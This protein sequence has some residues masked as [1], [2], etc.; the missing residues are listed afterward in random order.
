M[1]LVEA[2]R[3]AEWAHGQAT[4]QNARK[5][6]VAAI[7]DE[8]SPVEWWAACR[9]VRQC[10]PAF[11]GMKRALREVVDGG[12]NS[13]FGMAVRVTAMRRLGEVR[14][15][16]RTEANI[17][18]AV[19]C[20]D[21]IIQ[22]QTLSE[23][24]AGLGRWRKMGAARPPIPDARAAAPLVRKVTLAVAKHYESETEGEQVNEFNIGVSEGWVRMDDQP[25]FQRSDIPGLERS[26]F[27]VTIT[28]Y[29]GVFVRDP[30][31]PSYFQPSPVDVLAQISKG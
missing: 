23:V 10:S 1:R 22:M 19:L 9:A 29:G 3:E 24:A 25:E 14:D 30:S 6:A 11:D 7:K 20:L 21:G 2:D 5:W 27:Q 15:T 4:R 13:D 8:L 26:G 31:E 28:P 16:V 17:N 12:G 18:G